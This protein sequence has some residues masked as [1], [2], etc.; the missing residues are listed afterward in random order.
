MASMATT[1]E[2]HTV[3]VLEEL[4]VDVP[5]AVDVGG[6][7]I[8]VLR[9]HDDLLAFEDRCPHRG[10]P[11][12][13]GKCVDG[14]LRCALHGWEFSLPEGQAVSP[15]APFGLDFLEVRVTDGSVE[16]AV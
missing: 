6:R 11:L 14:I 9:L 8:C 13:D 2:F 1:G 7:S 3:T 12:S 10:H 5:T 4:T 15:R 16:V